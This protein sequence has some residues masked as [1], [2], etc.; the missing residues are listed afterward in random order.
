MGMALKKLIEDA[1][2]SATRSLKS[3]EDELKCADK[4]S[5]GLYGNYCNTLQKKIED[6]KDGSQKSRHQSDLKKHY[7][8][9]HSSEDKRRGA[10]DDIDARRISLGT[11]AGQLMGFIGSGQ[12]VKDALLKGLH[13]NVSQLEKLLN[14]SCGGE[15]CCKNKLPGIEKLKET[16]S[17]D[18]N[19]V[20]RQFNGLQPKLSEIEKEIAENISKLNTTIQRFESE[21]TAKKDAFSEKDSKS[22]NSHQS[23]M[24]SLETLNGLCGYAKQLETVSA[25]NPRDLLTN[26]CSG[27]E[28]F[29][30]F[31]PSSKGYDGTG[32]VYSDLDRLCDGMMAFLHGVLESVKDDDNVTTYNEYI[33]EEHKIDKVLSTL[34]SKI[35][36]GRG[37]L[38][39]SVTK[40]KEWLGKYNEEVGNKTGAVTEGLS[41]LIG[42]L[43]SDISSGAGGNEYYKEVEK[44]ENSGLGTQLMGWTSTVQ[45]IKFELNDIETRNIKTLDPTLSAQLT[46]KVDPITKVVEHLERVAGNSD[47][48]DKVTAVDDQFTQQEK[49]V[50]GQ[51]DKKCSGLQAQ[52]ST[53][54]HNINRNIVAIAEKR[55]EHLDPLLK[56]VSDLKQTVTAAGG[57]A[58]QLVSD[59]ESQIVNGLNNINEKKLLGTKDITT[60]LQDVVGRITPQL[61]NLSQHLGTL[62][63]SHIEVQQTVGSGLQEIIRELNQ[64]IGALKGQLNEKFNKYVKAYVTQVQ[65][66]VKRIKKEM[67]MVNP[68]GSNSELH[69]QATSVQQNIRDLDG[70]L[71]KGANAIGTAINLAA[72]GIN[73][74]LGSLDGKVRSGLWSVRE[75][76]RTQLQQ[77]VKGYV[78][79]VNEQ[80]EVVKGPGKEANTGIEGIKKRMKEYADAIFTNM[81]TTESGMMDEWIVK[82]LTN[83]GLV[84]K[85]LEDYVNFN[86]DRSKATKNHFKGSINGAN[87]LHDNIKPAIMN[88]LKDQVY[89]TVKG[90]YDVQPTGD[91][92]GDLRK[93]QNFLEAYAQRLDTKLKTPGTESYISKIVEDILKTIQT[94]VVEVVTNPKPRICWL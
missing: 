32:I 91:V 47:F 1:I 57:A 37:G 88:A 38:S 26:L 56:L 70:E 61:T 77:Y 93:L 78:T 92:A 12:E 63:N 7:S 73:N 10:L 15:G 48:A 90:T 60:Q 6:E 20:E 58:D 29:L 51:I 8:D 53:Q 83:N 94:A 76:L 62:R 45:K 17:S 13:S 18:E 80:V 82:I 11:L 9:V 30:G 16:K 2:E 46:H 14:A 86:K 67:T 36:S 4:G 55:T 74:A 3:K 64:Q 23:S 66:E 25:N 43:R 59:Y 89:A 33:D 35:G 31:N 72:N 40:V 5:D 22:L 71:D 54:F 68:N 87:D 27:L 75:G 28:T 34:Q 52:L 39:K 21:K 79:A 84:I 19:N 42:K 41:S 24:K 44:Q 50:R 49:H 65:G 69:Q 81:G 85:K